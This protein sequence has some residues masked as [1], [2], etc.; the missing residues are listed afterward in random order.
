MK[1][2]K[3][4]IS[5]PYTSKICSSCGTNLEKEIF[6]YKEKQALIQD[7]KDKKNPILVI[8]TIYGIIGAISF[9]F[10]GVLQFLVIFPILGLILSILGKNKG[11]TII[12]LFISIL[13]ILLIYISTT[14]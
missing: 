7:K 8:S 2:P 6:N 11:L 5:V 14:L 1:C 10:V 3:C 13:D 12:N 9:L 4:N